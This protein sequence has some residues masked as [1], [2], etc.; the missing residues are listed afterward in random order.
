MLE[1]AARPGG[2]GRRRALGRHVPPHGQP[3]PAPPR[4]AAGLSARLT[5]S[6]TATTPLSLV[7]QLR[8]G[9]EAADK[10]CSRSRR[11]CW[12][13]SAR[14]PTRRQPLRGTLAERGSA[15]IPW[16][17]TT[18]CACTQA[19]RRS[20][21]A[22]LGAMDFD[23][24]LVNGLRAV[25]RAPGR[26]GAVTRSSSCYVLVDE[27]QDTNPIQAELV[28]LIAARHR[29]LLV[30]GDDFQSIYSWRGADFRNIMTFPERYPDA[31]IFKLETNYRSVPEILDVANACIA[32]NPEQ[33]QKT[34][35]STRASVTKP[36]RWPACATATSRRATSPSSPAPAARRLSPPTRW[37][38]CTARIFT[39]WSCSWTAAGAGARIVI[40][41]GVRFFEQAHI[42]DVC[43]LL[44][45]LPEPR[46]RAGVPAAAGAAARKS[47]RRPPR[48]SGRSSAGVHGHDGRSATR[49]ADV[50]PRGRARRLAS[51]RAADP[52]LG[53][54]TS[55]TRSRA[56]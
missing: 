13:C 10:D 47:A 18:S 54:R 20:A 53:G 46:G 26:A 39:P 27:Y 5:R 22:R 19:L 42:K 2:A 7:R 24:L 48:K 38:C 15:D 36:G 9:A 51:A 50:L 40:T 21:S 3:H 43:S 28:D 44:R 52:G 23:D 17:W 32:G 25:P 29:N 31:R 33:F 45:L 16:T 11:C 41:S 35:R 4:R 12:A 37:P 34:L 56:R 55:A 1:R 30:V 49:F 6:W 14:R 8:Q